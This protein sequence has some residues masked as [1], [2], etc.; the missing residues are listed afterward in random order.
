MAIFNSVY[1]S[2]QWW[3]QPWANILAYYPLTADAND[4]KA[5][6]WYSDTAYNLT[7][8]NWSPSYWQHWVTSSSNYLLRTN[9]I[10]TQ[11]TY[12]A[13]C[14]CNRITSNS[15]THWPFAITEKLM[16]MAYWNSSN[17]KIWSYSWWGDGYIQTWVAMSNNTWYHL[18]YSTDGSTLTIYINWQAYWPYNYR[19]GNTYN[20]LVVWGTYYQSNEQS[21]LGTVW[22][23]YIWNRIVTSEEISEYY[24]Q[25]KWDY[26]IS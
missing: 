17:S 15:G 1:K 4:H 25:T 26:W 14:W 23:V 9:S 8:V 16:A 19:L 7:L 20:G 13:M 5:D 24:D 11:T 3:W 10:P 2:F 21:F 6:L 18:A 12:S 22:E